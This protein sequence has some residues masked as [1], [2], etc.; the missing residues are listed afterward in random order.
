MI[1][2]NRLTV[3]NFKVFGGEA[4][5]LNFKDNNLVILDGPNGYG[6]T[7]VFDALE[8]ALTGTISRLSSSDGRQN[9]AD[10][11]V[12]HNGA[13][14]IEVVLE[15]SEEG[16]D[17]FSIKKTLKSNLPR[18]ANKISKFSELWDS[19][20]SQGDS[21]SPVSSAQ[22]DKL[23]QNVRFTKDFLLF[24]YIQQEE[25]SVFLKSKN[26]SQ[27][28][29]ELSQLF[30]NT[31]SA[32][33]KYQ[34]LVDLQRQAEK[35]RKDSATRAAE[36]RKIYSLDT[37][38][39]SS[40]A[41][42]QPHFYLLHHLS[43][44]NSPEWDRREIITLNREKLNAFSSEILQIQ[45]FAAHAPY[46]LKQR[47]YKRYSQQVEVISSFIVGFKSLPKFE[48]I[49]REFETRRILVAAAKIF[50]DYDFKTARQINL[51]R[52]LEAV[53]LGADIS[54][55]FTSLDQLVSE[56][57]KLSGMTSTATRMAR[58]HEEFSR[59]IKSLPNNK[60]CPLCGKPY[61]SHDEL[62]A[63][64]SKTGE[65]LKS[66]IGEQERT[67][68]T[69]K[70]KFYYT[71]WGKV[72]R[73]IEVTLRGKSVSGVG[74][75]YLRNARRVIER[76]SALEAWLTKEGIQFNDLL[77]GDVSEESLALSEQ[78]ANALRQRIIDAAGVP[79]DQYLQDNSEGSF[80]RIFSDYFNDEAKLISDDLEARAKEKSKWLSDL[81]FNSLSGVFQD[82]LSLERSADIYMRSSEAISNIASKIRKQIRR[83]R[84]KLITDIEIPFY[85]YSGKILQTHQAGLGQGVLVKDSGDGEELK[86]VKLVSNWKSDHDILNTMSSGQISAV[87]IALSLALNKVYSKQFSP[88][89]IDDPVQT[90]DDI[91]MSSLV[92][93]L[94]NEFSD[95]QIVLS[96]H[97]EKV[98]R[99]F[100]YKF[101]KYKNS[102]RRI[103]MMERAEYV[104]GG[105]IEG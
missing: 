84:K 83:Y 44:R 56:E 26:E 24:H 28:A 87:V 38:A 6:K 41:E 89:L 40:Q 93:L 62:I 74:L 103:N 25:T 16:K 27:R 35:M 23:L 30:G 70:D 82:I 94:R 101:L 77:L 19:Y 13:K 61:D 46:Y 10:N 8:L 76:L 92:E 104:P 63:H 51:Y 96:T 5:S 53:G 48:D 78:N 12:A 85:I 1:K 71:L 47:S 75:D 102:V 98:S 7:S 58:Q 65:D 55:F 50:D 45:K 36:L 33:E 73:A 88:I 59:I 3:K 52:V 86:N 69:L 31:R 29:E 32:E 99:Y 79:S 20:V 95:R 60:D 97:E 34:K 72:A 91:N 100:T 22:L 11:V 67:F 66:L 9:P 2:L 43:E 54:E 18:D 14:E 15:L 4:Y 81:H 68:L 64:V 80:D 21:W 17:D 105:F 90:M 49:E 57:D 42:I 37:Q 39:V